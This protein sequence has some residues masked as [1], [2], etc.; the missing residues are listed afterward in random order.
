VKHSSSAPAPWPDGALVFSGPN[1]ARPIASEWDPPLGNYPKTAGDCPDFAESSQQN[2]TV[3]LPVAVFGQFRGDRPLRTSGTL[4]ED[5]MPLRLRGGIG[6]NQ[7]ADHA[8]EFRSGPAPPSLLHNG[9]LWRG[10]SRP[11]APFSRSPSRVFP[12]A[13]S[14]SRA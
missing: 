5:T 13:K 7:P 8:A 10:P 6:V 1:V 11:R 2:G 4:G 12:P 14:L 3:P 9:R